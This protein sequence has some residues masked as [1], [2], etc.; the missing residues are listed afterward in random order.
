MKR[1]NSKR[2]QEEMVGFV[3]IIVL[4]AVIVLIFL[5]FSIRR[6]SEDTLDDVEISNFVYSSL[7][8]TT[9]CYISA[10]RVY[11]FKDV[12]GGCSSG[13][14]CLDSRTTCEVLEETASDLIKNSWK[15]GNDE[16][17]KA[18][19]F[20]VIRQ[21]SS[22]FYL[23]EGEITTNKKGASVPIQVSG[24]KLYVELELYY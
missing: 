8:Y 23:S 3:L 14:I 16:V 17:Y 13:K 4:V 9:D 10:G 11:N 6:T 12:I 22:L 24:E 21:N 2:S 18:Y 15:I 20:N 7:E 19:E 5:A 1:I